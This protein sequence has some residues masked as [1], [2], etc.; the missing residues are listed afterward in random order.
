[1]KRTEKTFGRAFHEQE[2]PMAPRAVH[3]SATGQ[4]KPSARSMR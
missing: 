2:V 3:A 1:M 4:G